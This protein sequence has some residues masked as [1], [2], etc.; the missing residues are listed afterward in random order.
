MPSLSALQCF[1]NGPA[2][3]DGNPRLGPPCSPPEQ[4][5]PSHTLLLTLTAGIG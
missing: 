4:W 5:S 1:L 2:P 3:E